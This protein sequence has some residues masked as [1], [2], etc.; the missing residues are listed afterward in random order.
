[1]LSD[2]WMG[3]SMCFASLILCEGLGVHWIAVCSLMTHGFGIKVVLPLHSILK[4]LHLYFCTTLNPSSLK[5]CQKCQLCQSDSSCWDQTLTCTARQ[6][7][8]AQ[9]YCSRLSSCTWEA[10]AGECYKFEGSWSY[11]LSS[12][13]AGTTHEWFILAHIV[14][15]FGPWSSGFIHCSWAVSRQGIMAG[16]MS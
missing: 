10:K 12:R 13:P 8:W 14:R 6:K 5:L 3:W 16:S 1:M 11:I 15:G 9:G 4:S 2:W 7:S